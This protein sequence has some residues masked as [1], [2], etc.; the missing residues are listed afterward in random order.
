MAHPFIFLD[1]GRP[2]YT[3]E[4]FAGL[5]IEA[6]EPNENGVFTEKTYVD[7][8]VKCGYAVVLGVAKDSAGMYHVGVKIGTPTGG[9]GYSPSRKWNELRSKEEAFLEGLKLIEATRDFWKF[10]SYFREARKKYFNSAH[11]QLE[12][13]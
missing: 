1:K 4:D 9:G 2:V 5:E 7:I 13:F 12:L 6:T 10:R 8:P 11:R 3:I